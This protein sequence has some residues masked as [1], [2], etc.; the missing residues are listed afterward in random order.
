[1]G[2]MLDKMLKSQDITDEEA[3]SNSRRVYYYW[4]LSRRGERVEVLDLSF[5]QNNAK[6]YPIM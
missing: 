6:F 2:A 4:I 3:K 5:S 1:M